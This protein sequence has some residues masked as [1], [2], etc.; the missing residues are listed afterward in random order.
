MRVGITLLARV[1][2]INAYSSCFLRETE[3]HIN[4]VAQVQLLVTYLDSAE[5]PSL[6]SIPSTARRVRLVPDRIKL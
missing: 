4:V 2:E 5:L 1:C 6:M 3:A